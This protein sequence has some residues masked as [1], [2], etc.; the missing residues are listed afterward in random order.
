MCVSKKVRALSESLIRCFERELSGQRVNKGQSVLRQ[1]GMCVCVFLLATYGDVRK[2][3]ATVARLWVCGG[4]PHPIQNQSSVS[5]FRCLSEI[6]SHE[7]Q[8][9]YGFL[10]SD[11][12]LLGQECPINHQ[13]THLHNL[14]L[15]LLRQLPEYASLSNLRTNLKVT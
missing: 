1:R 13:R 10:W 12:F 8:S 14:F 3:Q 15:S 9:L 6:F 11:G 5:I 7:R 4:T 2:Y